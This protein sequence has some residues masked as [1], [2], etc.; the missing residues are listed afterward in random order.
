MRF[1]SFVIPEIA[2]GSSPAGPLRA[3]VVTDEGSG[4]VSGR[5]VVAER[6]PDPTE[7]ALMPSEADWAALDTMGAGVVRWWNDQR[8]IF[9]YNG[10]CM[11]TL[12][13]LNGRWAPLPMTRPVPDLALTELHSRISPCLEDSPELS[14]ARE[15]RRES[16]RYVSET[17]PDRIKISCRYA[18]NDREYGSFIKLREGL[19]SE[20]A[21]DELGAGGVAAA[22]SSGGWEEE[23]CHRLIAAHS[24]ILHNSEP[25]GQLIDILNRV[26]RLY[27]GKVSPIFA[28]PEDTHH[29]ED[30]EVSISVD[31][32]VVIDGGV[33]GCKITI[34]VSARLIEKGD[35][36]DPTRKIREDFIRRM[37]PSTCPQLVHMKDGWW[38]RWEGEHRD[39]RKPAQKI[40]RI[41]GTGLISWALSD[42]RELECRALGSG[43]DL[44]TIEFTLSKLSIGAAAATGINDQVKQF[45]CQGVD[46]VHDVLLS[47]LDSPTGLFI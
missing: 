6:S 43:W 12:D 2:C 13:L 35:A 11:V 20:E 47:L 17:H 28:V 16:V 42:R 30:V 32:V 45:V 29:V 31:N 36:T 44:G 46:R 21:V 15:R 38:V 7:L 10:K 8:H 34:P 37:F 24:L 18:F 4:F 41:G 23:I 5:P 27:S 1:H 25:L 26:T 9:G 33:N 19:S 22:R 14:A 3:H 40:K 39:E